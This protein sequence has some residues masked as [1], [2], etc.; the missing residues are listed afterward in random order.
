MFVSSKYLYYILGFS[1]VVSSSD[2]FF[3]KPEA[4]ATVA[5]NPQGSG[6][7]GVLALKVPPPPQY[8]PPTICNI[9]KDGK[10]VVS[11]GKDVETYIWDTT[12]GD[13]VSTLRGHEVMS[14]FVIR[15][16]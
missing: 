13:L 2:N 7:A 15:R 3:G 6:Y 1:I 12:H 10:L 9:S 5:R 16:A 11:G 4:S 14:S 8:A